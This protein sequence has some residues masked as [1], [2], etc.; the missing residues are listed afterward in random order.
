MP[1]PSTENHIKGKGIKRGKNLAQVQS[2]IPA[3]RHII[4]RELRDFRRGK[5]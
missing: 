4:Q 1:N 3:I 2:E 5:W